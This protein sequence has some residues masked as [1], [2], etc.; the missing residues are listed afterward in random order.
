MWETQKASNQAP[1]Y[2]NR[3]RHLTPEQESAFQA[4]GREAVIRFRI[5]DDAEILWKDLVRGPM[6]WRGAD[7]GG[8]MVVADGHL[9][10]RSVIR[11]TTWW[12]WWMTPPWPSP[13]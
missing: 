9:L 13:M 2:D 10:I 7:L 6:R 3:H 12:W 11:F 1:R 8:D 5:D 4:E